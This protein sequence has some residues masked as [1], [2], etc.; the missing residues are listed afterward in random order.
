MDEDAGEESDGEMRPR[1][2]SWENVASH[3][4]PLRQSAAR[5]EDRERGHQ[6]RHREAVERIV[7]GKLG[8]PS[9]SKPATCAARPRACS[10]G[11]RSGPRL[12]HR[13]PLRSISEARKEHPRTRV[14]PRTKSGC[15]GTASTGRHAL[16]SQD[17]PRDQVRVVTMLRSGELLRTH[18]DELVDLDGKTRASTSREAGQE[19]PR[20]PAAAVRSGG[21]DHQRGDGRYTISSS[22]AGSAMRRCTA[23]RWQRVARHRGQGQEGDK[24]HRHLRA[25]RAE[26]VHAARSAA[27]G[28][29]PRWAHRHQPLDHRG[30]PR[31]RG[32]RTIRAARCPGHRRGYDR[33]APE[34]K[35]A[36]LERWPA[37]CGA[38]SLSPVGGDRA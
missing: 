29:D 30:L 25:A 34:E 6:A 28:G 35:R 32:A 18:R 3:L 21:R 20:D 17:P 12:C 10:T 8:V 7:A 31:S 11:R 22:R 33:T 5:Q 36:A 26:A 2:E 13:Q 24:T 16:G 4:R 23:A 1:I 15:S 9:V 14:L 27:H 37:E 19:T 38:S